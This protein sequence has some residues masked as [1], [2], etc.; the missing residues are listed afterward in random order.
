[1][2]LGIPKLVLLKYPA[3]LYTPNGWNDKKTTPQKP[4]GMDS[5]VFLGLSHKGN[6]SSDRFS[7]AKTRPKG[8]APTIFG[9]RIYIQKQRTG[10]ESQFTGLPIF[11]LK[12]SSPPR[13]THLSWADSGVSCSLC[14]FFFSG[15]EHSF[16]RAK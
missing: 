11:P 3:S 4:R 15:A 10:G 13:D 14:L 9:K 6:S 5:L 8:K 16:S 7:L 1:M 2:S 12:T